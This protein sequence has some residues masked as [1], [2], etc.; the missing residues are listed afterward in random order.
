MLAAITF[1][2]LESA[3]IHTSA[4]GEWVFW[5]GAAAWAGTLTIKSL[6]TR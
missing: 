6:R 1:L 4:P 3:Q 2:L 5:A